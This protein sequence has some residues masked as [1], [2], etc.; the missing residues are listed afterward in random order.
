[1]TFQL[2]LLNKVEVI[3]VVSNNLGG[4]VRSLSLLSEFRKKEKSLEY[5]S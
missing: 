3:F 4:P 2:L 5:P 1:M